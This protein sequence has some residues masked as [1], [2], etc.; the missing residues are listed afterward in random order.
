VSGTLERADVERFRA[1]VG[2]RLGL[3]FEDGKLDSLAEIL[4]E[5]ME[6][7]GCARF[8]TY[9]GRL[10]NYEREELRALADQLTVAETY[11]FRYGDHFRAF[12]EVALP[13]RARVLNGHRSIHVLSAGCASG[14][15]AY[16][17]AMLVREH[18][19]AAERP[20]VE[21][22]GI[23]VNPVVIE[24]ARRARYS[25]WS[26]RETSAEIRARYFRLEGRELRLDEEVCSMA[27]FEERNLVD[28]DPHFWRAGA[29]DVVF[30]RN[31]MMYFSPEVM[32]AVVS[33]ITRAL[34]PGGFLFLGHAET[35]RGVSQDF[36]LRH[37]HE[38]FYYQR[39]DAAELGHIE[40]GTAKFAPP[41]P[42]RGTS[43]DLNDASWVDA[44][45]SASDRVTQLTRPSTSST[46][47]RAGAR[48]EPAPQKPLDLQ[49]ALLLLREERFAE[50][51]DLLHAL[52]MS[53]RQDPDAQLLRAALF[54]NSGKLREAEEVCAQILSA[55]ELSAGAHYLMALCREHAGDRHAALDHDQVATY[56]DAGF[57]MPHL[58]LGLLARR[59]GDSER[60]RAELGR[61][62]T[63]LAR[64]D[65]ARILLFGGGFSREALVELC[66]S[67]LRASEGGS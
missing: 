48:S 21:V 38:T 60:A 41:L 22:L 28:D 30:F 35:L 57:A 24:R 58:H 62:L 43:L 23:D 45:Q 42:S 37:T 18:F 64:E 65:A 33:R 34:S 20:L 3:H 46:N 26:L 17:L 56:L 19:A 63:L 36:H 31:V 16:S 53:S 5:R 6:V 61:A 39:R 40:S 29:F 52:P 12:V 67:E 32:S 1:I 66:R 27:S 47:A 49:P 14:E 9:E 55:D 59:G 44:I 4:R 8:A 25:P 13:D 2:R 11:F 51:M 7:H 10:A 54:T 50:A 15:E